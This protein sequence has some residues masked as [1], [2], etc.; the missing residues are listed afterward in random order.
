[1]HF[2]FGTV[3]R[4]RRIWREPTQKH[5]EHA[6]S[7]EMLLL[8]LSRTSSH[9]KLV[10]IYLWKWHRFQKIYLNEVL[11]GRGSDGIDESIMIIST[12][13]RALLRSYWR[14]INDEFWKFH[15]SSFGLFDQMDTRLVQS[16]FSFYLFIFF[17]AFWKTNPWTS[18]SSHLSAFIK[19]SSLQ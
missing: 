11:S 7:T 9:L 10:R 1:M 17:K 6:N 4:S 8:L 3:G 14:K 16:L 12:V 13:L 5:G 15:F 2:Y 19:P 18:S